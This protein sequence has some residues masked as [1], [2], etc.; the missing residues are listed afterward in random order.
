MRRDGEN[1]YSPSLAFLQEVVHPEIRGFSCDLIKISA[2]L[3]RV[4]RVR[5]RYGTDSEALPTTLIL[6]RI[7]PDWEDDPYGHLREAMVYASVLPALERFSGHI[8]FAGREA[9]SPYHLIVMEDVSDRYHFPPPTHVW[10]A[11]EIRAILQTYAAFHTYGEQIAPQIEGQSW[12]F[13]RHEARVLATYDDL[14]SM[15]ETIVAAG[16]WSPVPT[17]PK[18]LERTRREM[19]QRVESPLTLLHGDVYPPN[20]GFPI[21]S[22]DKNVYLLDWEMFSCGD[23]EMD[24]AY[25]FCQ[26][27]RSHRAINRT[28]AL[29]YYWQERERLGG[30]RYT[31]A[32]RAFRQRYA[33][34]LLLL[35]LIPV[36]YRMAQ[37]PY[38]PHSP[39]RQFWDSNFSMLE[40][41]LQTLAYAR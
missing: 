23:A 35:W 13:P 33:D 18:L 32:E 38:P 7:A 27:Y 15:V 17:F 1:D 11:E 22:P 24:L 12:L 28:R 4:Y 37:S 20:I 39:V 9:E 36:A 41:R 26:P 6:K 10:T 25:L 19:E 34:T 29:D 8:Y 16:Y 5:L 2:S 14:P 30:S 40:E 3:S 31:A 21:K